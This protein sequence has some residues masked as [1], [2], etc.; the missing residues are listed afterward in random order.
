MDL[1][2]KAFQSCKEGKTIFAGVMA[3]MPFTDAV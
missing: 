1:H 2:H 3:E